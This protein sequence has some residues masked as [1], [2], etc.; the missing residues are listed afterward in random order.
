MEESI[1]FLWLCCLCL[2]FEYTSSY[3]TET[4]SQTTETFICGNGSLITSPGY[5]S[6]YGNNIDITWTFSTHPGSLL[7]IQFYDFYLEDSTDYVYISS[8]GKQ[9]A[10]YT[11]SNLPPI[12]VSLIN[13]L[14]IVFTSDGGVSYRG[15]QAQISMYPETSDDICTDFDDGWDGWTHL[16][17]SYNDQWLRSSEG[18]DGSGRDN[19]YSASD[20]YYIYVESSTGNR[21][22]YLESP[23]TP[24]TWS[25]AC[26]QFYYYMS[27]N[28]KQYLGIIHYYNDSDHSPLLWNYD[29]FSIQWKH[30]SVSYDTKDG[31]NLVFKGKS[32]QGMV[33]VDD[34]HISD[35]NCPDIVVPPPQTTEKFIC[36][37]GSQ[38][39]TT[40]GYPSEYS[41]N[42]DVTWTFST[43]PG[44]LLSIQFYD[45]YLEDSSDYIYISSNGKQISAHTGSNLPPITVSTNNKL[46][47]VFISDGSISY[48]GFEAQISIYPA[49]TDGICTDFD[50]GWDGWTHLYPSTND[51]WL[52]SSEGIDGS[53]RDNR[54]SASDDYYIYVESSN[55]NRYGYLESPSTPPTWSKACLQFYYYMSGDSDQYLRIIHYYN[56][57]DHSTLL[58][59]YDDFSSQWKHASVSYDTKDGFNLVFKGKSHQGMVAVDD[60]Y[61]SKGHCPDIVDVVCTDSYMTVYLDSSVENAD[62][63]HFIDPTCTASGYVNRNGIQWIYL[64][65]RYDECQ[66]SMTSTEKSTTYHNQVMAYETEGIIRNGD[67]HIAVECELD[68]KGRSLVGFHPAGELQDLFKRE[69]ANFS[70]TMELYTDEDY[71]TPYPYWEYPVVLSLGSKVYVGAS[72][73]TFSDDMVIFVDSCK[74]TPIPDMD[75]NPQHQLIENNCGVDPT[76]EFDGQTSADTAHVFFSFESFCF[77]NYPTVFVHCEL[78]ICNGSDWRCHRDCGQRKRRDFSAPDKLSDTIPIALGPMILKK[79]ED[80]SKVILETEESTQKTIFPAFSTTLLLAVGMQVVLVV[81][82][83]LSKRARSNTKNVYQRLENNIDEM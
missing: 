5:P 41:N 74:A 52:R 53:G 82:Y 36:G 42:M 57:S 43:H 45:F 31:F 75:A 46:T 21:Y 33:A 2:T 12:T 28:S 50:E 30:A 34:I 55:R 10:A 29:D 79:S 20:D 7:S 1:W 32:H 35:G 37:N 62:N 19:R 25:K 60:I 54:Y 22:G 49:T 9:I 38:I 44:S 76:I 68:N 23:S 15:F 66:T 18:I 72:V 14:T 73:Q 24:P 40:P 70:F 78:S 63:V 48:R 56:I 67:F 8:D 80:D 64:H 81:G 71:S 65:T 39:I 4:P 3:T 69:Y 27:G 47:I 58:W 51:Q 13:K 26:L 11:G 6:D 59:N 16:Y 83:V 77:N 61:I 17:P